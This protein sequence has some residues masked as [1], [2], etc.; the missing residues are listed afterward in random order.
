[1]HCPRLRRGHEV[2]ECVMRAGAKGRLFISWFKGDHQEYL[3]CAVTEPSIV[4]HAGRHS[5]DFCVWKMH[6]GAVKA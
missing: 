3:S 6:A 2:L 5:L 4:R 1:M